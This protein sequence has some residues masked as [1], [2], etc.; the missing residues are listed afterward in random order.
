MLR[1]VFLA[2]IYGYLFYRFSIWDVI[3]LTFAISFFMIAIIAFSYKDN[4]RFS[5]EEK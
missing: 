5:G 2:L 3:G 1:A 4:T